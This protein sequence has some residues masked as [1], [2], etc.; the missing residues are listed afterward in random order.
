M[1]DDKIVEFPKSEVSDEEKARR[2][3]IELDRLT[4]LAPNE[5]RVWYKRSAQTLG[6]AHLVVC[7]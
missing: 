1:N 3:S 7:L 6:I 4:R 5:W 2:I